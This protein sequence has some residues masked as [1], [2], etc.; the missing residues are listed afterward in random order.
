MAGGKALGNVL[1]GMRQQNAISKFYYNGKVS[2]LGNKNVHQSGKKNLGGWGRQ[3]LWV[4]SGWSEAVHNEGG[5]L[6]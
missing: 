4:G 5:G 1:N 2:E 3:M 6:T